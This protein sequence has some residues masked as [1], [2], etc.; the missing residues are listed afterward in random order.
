MV[1]VR[2]RPAGAGSD[3]DRLRR[4]ARGATAQR[5]PAQLSAEHHPMSQAAG[6]TPLALAFEAQ[7]EG[8]VPPE[9][10]AQP[11][12]LY[13]ASGR[14]RPRKESARCHSEKLPKQTEMRKQAPS[15]TRRRA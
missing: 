7:L 14:A 3:R 11:V 6:P 4:I 1:R 12:V 5:L 2:E 9:A 13:P 8:R 10:S 15:P